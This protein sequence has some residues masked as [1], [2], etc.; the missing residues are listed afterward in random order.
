MPLLDVLSLPTP[1]WDMNEGMDE[2]EPDDVDEWEEDSLLNR[3][4]KVL[5]RHFDRIDWDALQSKPESRVPENLMKQIQRA[6]V[7]SPLNKK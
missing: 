3:C 7:P 1:A 6:R 4:V 2:F 5:G